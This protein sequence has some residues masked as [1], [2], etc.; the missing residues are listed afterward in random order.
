MKAAIYKSKH[1]L[2]V[3]DIPTPE[4]GAGQVLIKVKYSAICGTDV[5]AF[6]YDIVSP[7]TVMGHEFYGTIFRVGPG[8][9]HWSVG[10]R[11]V[12]GGGIPPAGEGPAFATEPRYNY[13]TDGF[14][15]RRIRGYAEYVLMNDWEPMAVQDGVSDM[16]AALSEPIAVSVHAVRKSQLKLGDSV[17]VLGAGP[18]GV[19]C[20]QVARAAG[21]SVV[22]VSEPLSNRQEAALKLGADE[23]FDPTKMDIVDKMVSLTEGLGPDLVFDCAGV[24]STVNQALDMARRNGQVMLLA[25]PW[26]QISILPVDWM[27]REVELQSTFG[28]RP[29]DWRVAMDLIRSGKVAIDPILSKDEFIPLD[30]I[31]EAFEELTKPTT[32]LQMVVK[33]D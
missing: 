3:E 18:I 14:A 1:R 8:V 29:V 11:V 26:K 12:G 16:A 32:Q 28:A 17:V 15:G 30:R 5:H 21:A 23:V 6:M 27:A 25:V 4:P 22:Y 10:D 7:G 9:S 20:L 19:F 33:M 2:S 13:R 24:G 31:Q